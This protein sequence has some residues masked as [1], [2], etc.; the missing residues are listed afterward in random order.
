MRKQ[1]ARAS[2][3]CPYP[4]IE[5]HMA[6][7]R[8]ASRTTC[9]LS[10]LAPPPPPPPSRP[11]PPQSIPAPQTSESKPN[12]R[13]FFF[14]SS[15]P[16]FLSPVSQTMPAGSRSLISPNPS[17]RLYPTVK[18]CLKGQHQK[19]NTKKRKKKQKKALGVVGNIWDSIRSENEGFGWR[20]CQ[21]K[22]F[23]K[24]RF[25]LIHEKNKNFIKSLLT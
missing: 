15:S 12:Q 19:Q 1:K 10:L 7:D 8:P 20:K 24:I 5:A 21:K 18:E 14:S 3:K 2:P 4:F 13:F 22:T 9:T 11:L 16:P 25:S 17:R 6:A 23:L